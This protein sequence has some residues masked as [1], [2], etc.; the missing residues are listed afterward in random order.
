MKEQITFQEHREVTREIDVTYPFYREHDC[1]GDNYSAVY[2]YKIVSRHKSYCIER[3]Y[4]FGSDDVE[5]KLEIRNGDVFSYDSD[6]DYILGKGV[7]SLTE[8]EFNEILNEF[9][10]HLN[11]V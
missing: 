7:Y 6:L 8:K 11:R 1:G 2:Y 10:K 5:Y 9:K 4:S 3:T